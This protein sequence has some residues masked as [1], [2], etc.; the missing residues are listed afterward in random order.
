MSICVSVC[1]SLSFLLSSPYYIA[2]RFKWLCFNW[3]QQKSCILADEMGLG[4]TIQSLSFLTYVHSHRNF[5][6][7]F[8][9][10]TPHSSPWQSQR[11]CALPQ[12]RLSAHFQT[13]R[14][15]FVI[16]HI[17]DASPSTVAARAEMS[18]VHTSSSTRMRT[19]GSFHLHSNSTCAS[20][21]TKWSPWP[22]T[23]FSL[24]FRGAYVWLMRHIA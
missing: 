13:G 8:L 21:P 11:S 2:C 10:G 9:I 16:G 23:K 24:R 3:H 19:T 4:K 18:S 14:M 20:P 6:G 22:G 12:W 15:R 1:P 5:G 17:C 7:P